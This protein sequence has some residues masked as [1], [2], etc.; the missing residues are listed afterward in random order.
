[1]F[2]GKVVHS[3]GP[4]KRYTS[5]R[6]TSRRC[7]YCRDEL[8]AA[9]RAVKSDGF[10]TNESHEP[11]DGAEVDY[12]IAAAVYH[13]SLGAGSRDSYDVGRGRGE[14][15]CL[16]GAADWCIDV[17]DPSPWRTVNDTELTG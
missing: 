9:N 14:H 4:V 8:A 11:I 17:D 5:G 13:Q 16:I 2:P 6:L 1:M 12:I 7:V 15:L 3:F 10:G